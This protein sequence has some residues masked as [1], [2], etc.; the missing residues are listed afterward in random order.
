MRANPG[1][2]LLALTV[3]LVVW[4]LGAGAPARAGETLVL[5]DS[6]GVDGAVSVATSEWKLAFSDRFNGGIHRWFDLAAD[7][8]ETDNLSTSSAGGFY[9]TGTL[10]TYNVYL[11]TTSPIEYTTTVGTNFASGALDLSILENT[12]TRVRIRQAGHPRL[13][14]GSGPAGDPFPELEMVDVETIWTLYP[15]GKVAIDFVATLDPSGQIVDSGPGGAGKGIDAAGMLVNA[16]GGADFQVDYVW[17]GDTIESSNGG[18]GPIQIASRSSPTQLVLASPV[19]LGAGL[20][21]VVRRPNIVLETISIHAD[22]D[23]TIV[24]QC[25]DPSTSHWQGGSNGDAL[26]TVPAGDGCGTFY[27]DT[28]GGQPPV[29]DDVLLAHWARTRAAG[30]LLA[31]FEPWAGVTS[32]F[33]NDLGFTDISYTQLGKAGIGP[34]TDHDRHFLAHLGSSAASVLPT[35]KSVANA[36]PYANDYRHPFA[37]ALVGTLAS[38][39]EIAAYGFNPAT[40]AYVIEAE[41]DV[42]VVRFD[43]FGGTRAG[44]RYYE[45]AIEVTDFFVADGDVVVERS[46]DGGATFTTLNP[47]N[48]NLTTQADEAQLGTGRRVL[49]YLGQIP[50]V[51]TGPTSWALR[52]AGPACGNGVVEPGLGEQCDE[53]RDNG[54][55]TSCCTKTCQLMPNGA[56]SCDGNLCTRTDVCTDGVCSPGPCADGQACSGCGGVCDDGGGSCS[57]AY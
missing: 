51:F 9:N 55:G 44:F 28:S 33:Y 41:N 30:S 7:P 12:S 19:P 50:G 21:Y 13:N 18:W 29:A 22:G 35:I 20:D 6:R 4:N 43:G 11:G 40:G 54:P 10:F 48:Y 24:N 45:P 46:S 31:L 39:P 1:S 23:P 5:T 57:C 3:S 49:Q 8:G 2:F 16:V 32:G 15:T 53:G 27:R 17:Q 56:A 34:F 25:S 36:Q 26:W 42:A 38:G 14:N 52:I 47:A 37:E